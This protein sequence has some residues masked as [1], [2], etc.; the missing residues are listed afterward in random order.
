MTRGRV[1]H[2]LNLVQA[3]LEE[4]RL[5]GT[6]LGRKS[7]HAHTSGGDFELE[8]PHMREF[9]LQISANQPANLCTTE[10]TQPS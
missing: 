4:S 2:T 9:S 8:I 6:N 1:L 3:N 10:L 7:V 5:V